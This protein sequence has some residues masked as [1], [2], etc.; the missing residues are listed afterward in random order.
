M[1]PFEEIRA[2]ILGELVH[3]C[4]GVLLD[5]FLVI[6]HARGR[7]NYQYYRRHWIRYH[8]NQQL[9]LFGSSKLEA[10]C[11]KRKHLVIEPRKP[12]MDRAEA[13]DKE[14]LFADKRHPSADKKHP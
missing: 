7:P 14:H 5:V 2:F 10:E 6:L 8:L 1:I 9:N 3:A 4:S 11:S 12:Q 13:G